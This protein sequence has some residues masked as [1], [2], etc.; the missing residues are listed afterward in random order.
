MNFRCAMILAIAFFAMPIPANLHAQ[1][2]PDDI[3]DSGTRLGEEEARRIL[4]EILPP[5]ATKQQQIQYYQRHERAA[6]TLGEA[7][8]R[9]EALR[10]LVELTGEPGKP[11]PYQAYLWHELWRYG[12]QTEALEMGEALVHHRGITPEQR[13]AWTVDL[14]R[15][16]MT[17]GNRSRAA[18]LLKQAEAEAKAI[19][20]TGSVRMIAYTTI[21][22]ED[23]R[24]TV[25]QGQNDPEGALAA[26][27]RALEASLV[28]VKR[29][30][31]AVGSSGTDLEYDTALR[32]RNMA[33]GTAIWL[34]F[35]QGRNEEAEGL[36]RLGLRLSGEERTG[37]ATI[38]FWHQKLAQ[39][40]LGERRY[41]EAAT[42]ANEALSVLRANAATES[43]TRTIS[44]QS[45]LL[46]AFLA[47]GRWDDADRLAAEM[48]AATTSDRAARSMVDNPAL[49]AF[50]HLKNDRIGQARERI[51]SLV[52]YRQRLYG[53]KSGLTIEA[54]AVRALVLQ[55]QGAERLALDDYR[56]V[57][58]YVFAPEKSFGDAQP[59]GMRG[60]YLPQ[61][62]R[63]FLSLVQERFA[64]DGA[65]TD[66]EL[67][68][69]AFRIAD[70]LQLST[71][72]RSLI[73]SAARVVAA[74]PDLA[75]LVRREQEQR[76][77]SGELMT[78]LNRAYAEDQRLAKE[79][80]Q[81]Q[82]EG[83][84]A[85]EDEKKLAQ[86]AAAERE[87]ARARQAALKQLRDQLESSEKER[88]EMQVEI[89]RRFPEYQLLVNPK[90]PSLSE[91]SR[92]L[93]KDEA[94]VGLYPFDQGTFVWGISAGGP[95]AFHVSPLKPSEIRDLVTR[96]R[97]TLDLGAVPTAGTAAFDAASSQRLFQELLA[98][99]WPALGAPR[100]VT[101]ATAS[102][103]AQLPLAVLI[104]QPSEGAFDPARANWLVR[105]TAVNQ[106][107]TAAAFRAL[108][109]SR[110]R[111]KP[112][113]PFFGFGDPLFMIAAA[114][115]G[116]G[117]GAR[118]VQM[119]S[120]AD[121][122]GSL[123]SPLPE[124]RDEITA[125]A[126]ALGAE[127][128]KDARFGAQATRT[129]ALTTDLSNRRVVA[130]ATHGLRPGDLPGLS[131]PAL[132]MAATTQAES[133][134]LTLDDVLTMKLN[135][136]WI[137][138]S[139]CNTASDDGR[140][141][142]AFSGL[143][144]A[145]FFSGARSVLATHWA[146]ESLSAQQLVTRTFAH[147]AGN[148]SASRAES[149]RQAQLQLI[150]GKAGAGY[151]YPFFWAPYAVYGDPTM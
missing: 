43:S 97:K 31:S 101:I 64:K 69:L 13:I 122:Y 90:P 145:F 149:L 9:I 4:A 56:A 19:Q 144:R 99:V 120:Q 89:G 118:G 14:G 74:T 109:A 55:A 32:Q 104:T 17:L 131:R 84:A 6:Y 117:P 59:S 100:V 52:T 53:E 142:E 22:T 146:V 48:R 2:E 86:E 60:F 108:R 75:D 10:R 30:R 37:G 73:D 92:L 16:Y 125:I 113:V 39:A 140:T 5:D 119:V 129:A 7:A 12:S 81:R 141:Q 123:L 28:E 68:D 23:L 82:A 46:Q 79:A 126:K 76:V 115:G 111:T 15:N 71:V 51:D 132:A 128:G 133:P 138:L 26:T 105:E 54:R 41:P 36:A 147:Q 44:T 33:M 25:L 70:R 110:P 1:E 137:V 87:R 3:E 21:A 112:A 148:P 47:L 91:L 34:Y 136:D 20:S 49:Q 67:V 139:A 18:E 38:A 116:S 102:E 65:A 143:A 24:A 66:G 8:I 77:K 98:P 50:L 61:A 134:L 63:G 107:A 88:G 95:P 106:I 114:S 94:F 127:L 124:T 45:T 121:E 58:S 78:T 11:S 83:K 27:R 42:A 80:K 150:E 130:F 151:A 85:K 62:L 57:F 29:C 72:Q 40:L 93:S 96:L 35:L 103:L 135:A